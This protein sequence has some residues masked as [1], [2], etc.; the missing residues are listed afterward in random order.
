VCLRDSDRIS[1]LI[2]YG[3]LVYCLILLGIWILGLLSERKNLLIIGFFSVDLLRITLSRSGNLISLKFQAFRQLLPGRPL[4]WWAVGF[5]Y[6]KKVV[7]EVKAGSFCGGGWEVDQCWDYGGTVKVE[8][9]R[10]LG[11]Y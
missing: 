5:R 8:R 9:N 10:L 1:F 3:F 6:Y 11:K 7:D 2:H 4:M